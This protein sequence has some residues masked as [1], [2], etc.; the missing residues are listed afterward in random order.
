MYVE[1]GR[2]F[3][4][5]RKLEGTAKVATDLPGRFGKKTQ[6]FVLRWRLEINMSLDDK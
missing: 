1:A 2:L 3:K 4:I 5:V 6:L